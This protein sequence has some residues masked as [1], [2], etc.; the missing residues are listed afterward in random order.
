LDTFFHVVIWHGKKMAD[1]KK[2][3]YQNDPNY[4]SFK[5]LLLAPLEDAKAICA[6][7]FVS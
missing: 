1:W 3:G 4:A 5:D 6:E 2:K 7:R